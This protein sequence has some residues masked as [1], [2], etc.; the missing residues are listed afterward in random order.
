MTLEE[1]REILELGL[2]ASRREIKAAYRRAARRW[3]PDRAPQG[4]EPEYRARMQEVNDA[5]QRILKFLEGYRYDLTEAAA[6][7]YE[8]WWRAHFFTGVWGTPP[9]KGGKKGP[10]E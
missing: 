1:A 9:P 3:H 5:Y 10:E 8:S 2:K 6:V 7:D 4:G